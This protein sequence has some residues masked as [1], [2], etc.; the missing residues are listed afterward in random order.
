MMM[1]LHC[2]LE[3]LPEDIKAMDYFD[4]NAEE[5]SLNVYS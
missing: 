3:Q 4:L 1:Y 5:Y 2:S